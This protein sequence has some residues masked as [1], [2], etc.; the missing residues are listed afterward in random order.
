MYLSL[1]SS[2]HYSTDP[3]GGSRISQMWAPNPKGGGSTDLLFGQISFWKM[4]KK[5]EKEIGQKRGTHPWRPHFG[6][7]NASPIKQVFLFKRCHL[8]TWN[9]KGGT[10]I[11]LRRSSWRYTS[12]Y[13]YLDPILSLPF[14]EPVEMFEADKTKDSMHSTGNHDNVLIS[15]YVFL[16]SL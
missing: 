15:V 2:L 9:C 16:S 1:V 4:H 12:T 7:N 11:S 10:K 13:C 8:K 3:S 14:W 5:E 6:S